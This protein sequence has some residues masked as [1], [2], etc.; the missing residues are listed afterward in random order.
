[1]GLSYRDV[2]HSLLGGHA[3]GPD[4]K[5]HSWPIGAAGN[6]P[7]SLVEL[8]DARPRHKADPCGGSRRVP[9]IGHESVHNR[10]AEAFLSVIRQDGNIDNVEEDTTVADDT[11]HPDRFSPM[12]N[13]H[14]IER[15]CEASLGGQ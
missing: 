7:V 13:A 5:R 12:L 2:G 11:P 1:S 14:A 10:L 4:H 3:V 6:E 8:L 15:V 9:D